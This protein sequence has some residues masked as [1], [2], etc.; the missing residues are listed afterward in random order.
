M[1]AQRPGNGKPFSPGPYSHGGHSLVLARDGGIKVKPG[2]TISGYSACL[3]RDL[4]KGWEEYGEAVGE[5]V[6]PLVDPHAIAAGGTVYHIPTWEAVHLPVR[7]GYK[8]HALDLVNAFAARSGPQAFPTMDRAEVAEGLRQRIRN[9]ALVNQGQAHLCPSALIVFLEARDHPVHY[10]LLVIQLFELGQTYL[11]G[12]R[13]APSRQLRNYLPR[14]G[15]IDDVD[16]I[17]MASIR[18]SDEWFW[19]NR[20][21]FHDGGA[22]CDVIANWLTSAGYTDVRDNSSRSHTETERNLRLAGAYHDMGFR[23]ILNFDAQV[24]TAPA[25]RGARKL[26]H[27]ATLT[28]PI[29]F[30]TNPDGTKAVEI[31]VQTWGSQRQIIP[32]GAP[33]MLLADFLNHYYGFVAARF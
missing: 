23:V 32:F 20:D 9:P 19:S 29:M 17:P 5:G 8:K 2:D 10:V 16:W 3:Y 11:R 27:V 31:T 15:T 7:N 22:Y 13:I 14:P 24:L 21:V 4:F 25:N 6:L 30:F 1:V 26:M 12:W 18:E 33:S 28:Y